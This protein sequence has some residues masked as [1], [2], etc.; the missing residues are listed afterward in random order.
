MD[1]EGPGT[2]VWW[3]ITNCKFGGTIRVY[4][5]ASKTAVL[6]GTGDQ[7][8]GGTE[9][10]RLSRWRMSERTAQIAAGGR[11]EAL[12]KPTLC[13]YCNHWQTAHFPRGGSALGSSPFPGS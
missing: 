11:K 2:I 12:S 1:V 7:L 10:V 3:W 8:L 13:R 9:G 5:D 6:Q 4:L